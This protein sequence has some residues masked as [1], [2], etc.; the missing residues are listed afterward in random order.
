MRQLHGWNSSSVNGMGRSW[1]SLRLLTQGLASFHLG[2]CGHDRGGLPA[3]LPGHCAPAMSRCSC[4]PSARAAFLPTWGCRPMLA[5]S[6]LNTIYDFGIATELFP[7]LIFIGV[8]AMLDF[9]P[10]LAQPRLVVLFGR[11]GSSASMPRCSWPLLFGFQLPEAASIGVIGAIDGP[12]AIFV[13]L[14]NWRPNCSVPSP[15]PPTPT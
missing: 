2:Q 3:H 9:R 8:G 4:C 5:G 6:W 11:P 13:S 7:L 14:P 12:T 10:L 1:I 15:W